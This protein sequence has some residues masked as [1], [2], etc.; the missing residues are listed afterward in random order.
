M[1]GG[2]NFD[3]VVKLAIPIIVKKAWPL[4]RNRVLAK[5]GSSEL[6]KEVVDTVAEQLGEVLENKLQIDI[7]GDGNIGEVTIVDS[8]EESEATDATP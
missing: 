8:E 2:P 7:D 5:T 3:G 4:V 6:A 1:T